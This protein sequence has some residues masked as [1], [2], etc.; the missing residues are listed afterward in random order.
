MQTGPT[1]LLNV[2]M[3]KR[4]FAP[5]V[6]PSTASTPAAR[7]FPASW[8]AFMGD[9]MTRLASATAR[10]QDEAGLVD[11]IDAHLEAGLAETMG[12]YAFE[13]MHLWRS[14][15]VPV[16][17]E[18]R[19]HLLARPSETHG[20]ILE[21]L[22]VQEQ[23]HPIVER[24]QREI[25]PALIDEAVASWTRAPL[26]YLTDYPTEIAA[27][28]LAQDRGLLASVLVVSDVAD[29]HDETAWRTHA[30]ALLWRDGVRASA[31][32]LASLCPERVSFSL[33]P[34]SERLDIDQLV[35]VQRAQDAWLASIANSHADDVI[36]LFPETPHDGG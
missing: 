31:R 23:L 17:E 7:A 21:A 13:H 6:A 35:A 30:S 9:V 8:E 22:G 18:F 29:E 25:A 27:L 12:A 15:Q 14:E 1:T 33:V 16:G 5:I 4:G 34:R 11:V 3:R 26:A 28:F 32:L 19:K 2:L 24:L 10:V 36:H 20:I